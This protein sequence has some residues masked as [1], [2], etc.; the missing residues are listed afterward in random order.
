M[1]EGISWQVTSPMKEDSLERKIGRREQ[2]STVAAD[3][4]AL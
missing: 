2:G 4:F 1:L 3:S